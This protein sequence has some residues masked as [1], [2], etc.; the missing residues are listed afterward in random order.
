MCGRYHL[1][2]TPA[3]VAHHFD[4]DVRDNFPPRYNIAPTQP[5]STIR[6][7]EQ[8]KREYAL[9][10]WGFVPSWAK[11]EYLQRLGSKP[12]INARSETAAEK[13]TFRHAFKR[14]RCL[15]PADGFYEWRGEAGDKQPYNLIR[16]GLFGFAGLWETAVDA[17]GGEI[18]TCAILTIAA[19]PDVRAL[20]SREPIVIAP[21]HYELWLTA[22]E[23]DIDYLF[24]LL[25]PAPKG[26]WRR[27]PVSK[28]VGS[29][30][31]DGPDLLKEVAL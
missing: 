21:E 9:I 14:R 23:R 24:D 12:L 29:P 27:Y 10:R 13:P 6:T 15:I 17:E 8:R 28:A 25:R 5:I 2:S 3:D 31:N 20:S 18:D 1:N 19:G 4:V 7:S 30:R 26:T 22:D 16:G 11:G